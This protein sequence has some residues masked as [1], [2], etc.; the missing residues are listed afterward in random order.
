MPVNEAL[1]YRSL[2]TYRSLIA[3]D[4]DIPAYKFCRDSSLEEICIRKPRDLSALINIKG[5]GVRFIEK[6]GIGFQKIL[7]EFYKKNNI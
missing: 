4:E 5:I 2:K 7:N 3:N 6:Y 1:L